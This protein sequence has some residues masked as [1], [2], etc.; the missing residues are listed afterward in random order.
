MIDHAGI[1]DVRIQAAQELLYE[2]LIKDAYKVTKFVSPKL[3]V[4]AT[5]KRYGKKVWRDEKQMQIMLTIGPPNYEEREMLKRAKKV[6]SDPVNLV[7]KHE[8][9]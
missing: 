8:K 9:K 7:I 1:L 6:S 2:I 4:K 5:R 3:T